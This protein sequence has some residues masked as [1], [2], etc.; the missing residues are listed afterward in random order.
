MYSE[1]KHSWKIGNCH[2]NGLEAGR[3][4]ADSR[5]PERGQCNLQSPFTAFTSFQN[6]GINIA[7]KATKGTGPE[8]SNCLLEV[9]CRAEVPVLY[10]QD[11][12]TT[13]SR[14]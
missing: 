5:L 11:I 3:S 13:E 7:S 4:S 1:V 6:L 8:Q 12:P 9:H 2:I 10:G 14:M